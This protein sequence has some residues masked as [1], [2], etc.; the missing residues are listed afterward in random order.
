[1]GDQFIEQ[2]NAVFVHIGERPTAY[3]VW[4]GTAGAPIP[5]HKANV[6]QFP[7]CVAFELHANRILVLAIAHAKRRPLYWLARTSRGSG[8][9]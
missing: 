7:Y 4:L 9:Q 3:P 8:N 5:I 1:L 6:E 2:L